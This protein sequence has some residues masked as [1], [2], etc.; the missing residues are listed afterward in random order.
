VLVLISALAPSKKDWRGAM[1][2]RPSRR[3]LSITQP[4]VLC[5]VTSPTGFKFSDLT[6]VLVFFWIYSKI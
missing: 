4:W 5:G 3:E 2:K 1:P 6:R